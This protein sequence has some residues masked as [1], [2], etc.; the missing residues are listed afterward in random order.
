MVY[1]RPRYGT[2]SVDASLFDLEICKLKRHAICLSHAHTV[3]RE[4]CGNCNG[5]W[6]VRAE[7]GA[8]R[9]LVQSRDRSTEVTHWSR[10]VLKSS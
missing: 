8:L 6:I 2:G 4:G 1:I 7:T 9:S 10:V 5:R 3:V